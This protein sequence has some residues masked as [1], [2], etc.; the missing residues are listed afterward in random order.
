[1]LKVS[2]LLLGIWALPASVQEDNL[3]GKLGVRINY[4]KIALRQLSKLGYT[5]D[6]VTNG[7]EAI[8]AFHKKQYALILMDCMMPYM[9][10]FEAVRAIRKL[11][12]E[13]QHIPVIAL[14]AGV[15]AIE[16]EN[17]FKAGMDAFL[18]KPVKN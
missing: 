15:T 5:V 8:E 18:A 2:L 7:L 9:D 12:A 13:G 11:E 10:G 14:S 3:L 17:C 6:V 16:R 1:V 4:Q